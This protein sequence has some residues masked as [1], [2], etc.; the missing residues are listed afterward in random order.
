M[1]TIYLRKTLQGFAP[2]TEDDQDAVRRFK[3]GEVVRAK[4]T[5]ARNL[6]FFRKWWALVKV[7]YGLW[8]ELCPRPTYKGE[9]V[10]PDF[11][12]F[13]R[14][15]TILAGFSRPV[16]NIRGEVR[17]EAESIAFGNMSEARFEALYSATINVLLHK[18]LAGSG[19]T[20]E[21]IRAMANSVME[22]A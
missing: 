7:G 19:V 10:H 2:D 21:K 15:V 14:D 13:R 17:V 9:I 20:E 4:V 22:F 18:V 11:D 1:T 16:V 6:A 8:E 12:R 3:L 5:R